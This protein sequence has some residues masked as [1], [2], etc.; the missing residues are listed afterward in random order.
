MFAAE[1]FLIKTICVAYKNSIVRLRIHLL[2]GKY[3]CAIIILL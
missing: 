1:I 3:N 2:S